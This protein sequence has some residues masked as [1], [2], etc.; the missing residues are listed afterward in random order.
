MSGAGLSSGGEEHF[1]VADD[2]LVR[3]RGKFNAGSERQL[4]FTLSAIGII[5]LETASQRSPYA[6][7][8]S[9]ALSSE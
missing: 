4:I 1:P 9:K 5:S 8:S 2:I 3:G 6:L 7:L